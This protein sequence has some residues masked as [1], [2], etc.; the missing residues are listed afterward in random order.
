MNIV[1]ATIIALFQWKKSEVN[2]K[3]ASPFQM[4]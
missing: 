2:M 1:N 3:N 4:Q